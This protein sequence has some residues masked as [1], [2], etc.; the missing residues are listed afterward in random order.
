VIRYEVL[1]NDSFEVRKLVEYLE[2]QHR[3]LVDLKVDFFRRKAEVA[4]K[5]LLDSFGSQHKNRGRENHCRLSFYIIF[6]KTVLVK[7][8]THTIPRG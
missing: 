3:F 7:T 6:I 2:T 8:H 5:S 4:K 1:E